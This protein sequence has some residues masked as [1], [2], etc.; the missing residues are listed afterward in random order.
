MAP[1]LS[2]TN[3]AIVVM[4]MWAIVYTLPVAIIAIVMRRHI[5]P[6]RNDD[7]DLQNIQSNIF[8]LWATT[9]A[10][11]VNIALANGNQLIIA[12]SQLTANTSLANTRLRPQTKPPDE[13]SRTIIWSNI[14]NGRTLRLYTVQYGYSQWL[15]IISNL[16]GFYYATSMSLTDWYPCI[17]QLVFV[18]IA[19]A[20]R[21]KV[22]LLPDELINP[23]TPPQF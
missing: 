15:L 21:I 9:F 22:S 5:A 2:E 3:M 19:I 17:E 10:V 20:C 13:V 23:V 8:W 18:F 7:S 6:Q 1:I 11:S 14:D 16:A 4:E 12:F